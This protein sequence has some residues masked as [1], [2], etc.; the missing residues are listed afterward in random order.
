M[1]GNA[2]V[3]ATKSNPAIRPA[4]AIQVYFDTL[5]TVLLLLDNK[6]DDCKQKSVHASS[7]A[8]ENVMKPFDAH[9]ALASIPKTANV[10]ASQ[11]IARSS[12]MARNFHNDAPCR[13][14]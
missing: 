12:P 14:R 9:G 7:H 11:P 2:Q 13:R 3:N 6:K 1:S 4:A 8:K 10:T 5:F